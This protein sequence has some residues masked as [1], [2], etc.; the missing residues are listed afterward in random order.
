ME[1]KISLAKKDLFGSAHEE[2]TL[3][4]CNMR[5]NKAEE[6]LERIKMHY[7]LLTHRYDAL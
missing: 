7:L 5:V 6:I 2:E 3:V 4:I 1:L